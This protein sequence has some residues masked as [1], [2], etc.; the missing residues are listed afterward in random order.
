MT[1]KPLNRDSITEAVQIHERVGREQEMVPGI[2]ENV[3][4][5]ILHSLQDDGFAEQRMGIVGNE[6]V[7]MLFSIGYHPDMPA[8]KYV[9]S[10]HPNDCGLQPEMQERVK[11]RLKKIQEALEEQNFPVISPYKH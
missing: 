5:D 1:Y 3:V 11:K 9:I 4:K 7:K 8:A 2:L 10:F 6:N